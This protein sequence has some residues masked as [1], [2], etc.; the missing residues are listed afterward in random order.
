LDGLSAHADRNDILR[1]L[2]GF[3]RAPRHLYVVHGEPAAAEG[4]CAAVRD[5]LGWSVSVA[6]DGAV[7]TL[8]GASHE[9]A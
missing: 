7:V 5:Q 1:W 6:E 2:R 8:A 9:G 4:L 3:R